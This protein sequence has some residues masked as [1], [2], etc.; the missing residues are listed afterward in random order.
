MR[1]S[2]SAGDTEAKREREWTRVQLFE[3]TCESVRARES[4]RPNESESGREFNS[5][6]RHEI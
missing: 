3:E 6:C 1:V 5:L 2:E 4:L